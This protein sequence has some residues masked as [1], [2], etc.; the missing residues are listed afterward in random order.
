MRMKIFL[1]SGN[2]DL[3]GNL[4]M[5]PTDEDHIYVG[6]ANDVYESPDAG[7][8]WNILATVEGNWCIS[9]CKLNADRLYA[10]GSNSGFARL[11]R[12][13]AGTETILHNALVEEGFVNSKITDIEVST[14]NSDN[15]YISSCRV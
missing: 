10:A 13:E 3:F 12:I 2:E 6:Y 11:H 15:V 14:T 9:T 4:G 8:T 7:Q 1:V 5:D